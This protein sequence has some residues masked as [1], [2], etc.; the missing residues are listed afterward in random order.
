MYLTSHADGAFH[1]WRQRFPDGQPEQITSGPAEEEGIAMAPDGRSFITSVGVRQAAVWVHDSSGERQIS[2]EGYSCDP[3]FT[4][5]GKNLLYRIVQGALL[6]SQSELRV[7]DLDSGH[8]E[9]L[10]PGFAVTGA[11]AGYGAYDIS[12]DG[13]E[14]VVAAPDH[15]GK[16]RLWLAPLDRRSPPRQIPN[17]EGEL[18]VFGLG[19]EVFFR[20]VEGVSAFAYRVLKDGTGLRKAIEQPVAM[21][22]SISPDGHWLVVKLPGTMG[23]STTA[24]PLRGGAP[25]PICA[26]IASESLVRWSPDGR[27]IFISLPYSGGGTLGGN[28]HI[29]SLPPGGALPRIPAGGFRSE[30]EIT[31][32]PG[33]RHIDAFHVAPSPTPGV[34]AFSRESVQ[35]NLY[36]IPLP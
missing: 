23:S 32:L 17:V 5:D 4:P 15:E 14:V 34:Y 28:T 30:A 8:N 6:T 33:A 31:K 27:L 24:F 2:L 22:S 3:K 20:A 12:P 36:R 18:P 1:I 29:V 25:V 10:L 19:G 11:W 13:Q 7:V 26:G 21:I 16:H 9:P 35:R